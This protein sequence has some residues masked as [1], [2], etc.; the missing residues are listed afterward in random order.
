MSI[1][2]SSLGSSNRFWETQ[3][4][5]FIPT[6]I[7]PGQNLQRIKQQENLGH[8]NATPTPTPEKYHENQEKK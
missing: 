7:I 8:G 3:K 1:A 2:S 4:A 5:I 6:H